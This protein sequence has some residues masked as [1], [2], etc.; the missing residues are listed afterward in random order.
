MKSVCIFSCAGSLVMLTTNMSSQQNPWHIDK[1]D[2]Q[3]DSW[4]VP[5]INV[6][7]TDALITTGWKHA[8]LNCVGVVMFFLSCLM[9][10]EFCQCPGSMV[11]TTCDI[12][13]I[14][15]V[16]NLFIYIDCLMVFALLDFIVGFVFSLKKTNPTCYTVT[17]TK[18]TYSFIPGNVFNVGFS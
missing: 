14:I 10:L 16:A 11:Y 17:W 18:H 7:R 2:V 4:L 12:S 9:L 5:L 13:H 1:N 15:F 8:C 3:G 6:A